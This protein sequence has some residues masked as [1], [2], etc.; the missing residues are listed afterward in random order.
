[1]GGATRE[2]VFVCERADS[3]LTLELGLASLRDCTG[4]KSG[5]FVGE[6]EE[7]VNCLVELRRSLWML[8]S[9]FF[10][11]DDHWTMV[12]CEVDERDRLI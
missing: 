2:V 3:G 10:L 7:E 11:N 6:G 12:S 9:G 8:K 1:M 5:R 4:G